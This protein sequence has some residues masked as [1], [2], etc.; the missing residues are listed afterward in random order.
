MNP[1]DCR[2]ESL[3]SRRRNGENWWESSEATVHEIGVVLVCP[4]HKLLP[5]TEMMNA[6]NR[7]QLMAIGG[8]GVGS[9]VCHEN[10]DNHTSG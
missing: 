2:S 7:N 6:Q 8:K 10:W 3:L 9:Y 5:I 4:S 1:H